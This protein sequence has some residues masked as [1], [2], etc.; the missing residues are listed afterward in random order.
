MG[1][2]EH[3]VLVQADQVTQPGAQFAHALKLLPTLLF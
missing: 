1:L 2:A 3:A